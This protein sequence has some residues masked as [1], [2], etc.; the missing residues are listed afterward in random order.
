MKQFITLKLV[1]NHA[2]VP[3]RR[4]FS[5]RPVVETDIP[6]SPDINYVFE[7]NGSF[8]D[9]SGRG[10]KKDSQTIEYDEFS[11]AQTAYHEYYKKHQLESHKNVKCVVFLEDEDNKVTPILVENSFEELEFAL[12]GA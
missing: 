6:T 1:S 12:T 10:Y 8:Y 7:Y 3:T 5:A 9:S 2:I 4:I 11:A